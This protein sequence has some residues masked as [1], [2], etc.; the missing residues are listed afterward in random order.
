MFAFR[1]AANYY[2]PLFQLVQAEW[3]DGRIPLWNPYENLGVPLAANSTASVFYPGKLFFAVPF[4]YD[5]AYK[6]YVFSHVL[7]AAFTSYRLARHWG[8]GV[9]GAGV[10]AM[11]YAFCGNVIMQ[12][13]NV[14]YLIGAAWL[15]AALLA[16]DHMLMNRSK[17]WAVALGIILGLI[18]LGGDPQ[19]AYHVGLLTIFYALWCG[20]NESTRLSDVSM[21]QRWPTLLGISVVVALVLS[22]VQVVPSAE[23][24]RRCNRG[25]VEVP[26]NIYEVP[27]FVGYRDAGKRIADGLLVRSLNPERHR[28]QLYHF[29]VGPW[30]LSEYIFPNVSGRQYPVHRRWL[31][32]VPAEGRVW[33]PSLY[34]GLLPFVLAI[35][36]LRFGRVSGQESWLSWLV[37]LAILASFGW[38]GLTWLIH[39]GQQAV[40][41]PKVNI[42]PPVGGLYWMLTV[43]L[44]GY[45]YFRYP[46]K[47]LIIAALALSMLSARGWEHAFTERSDK[48][49]KFLLI[50]ACVSLV[51]TVA[52][53]FLSRQLCDWLAHVEPDMLF[54]PLD[55]RGAVADMLSATLQTAI[56]SLFA[57]GLLRCASGGSRLASSIAV[58]LV[59][60]D[61][62]VA[63]GWMVV[64]APAE[65]WMRGKSE[66]A[67]AVNEAANRTT[68]GQPYRVGRKPSWVSSEWKETSSMDRLAES[69][70]WERNTLAPKY[71]LID[72]IPLSEV[73]G[74]AMPKDYKAVLEKD[75]TIKGAN[76]TISIEKD[77]VVENQKYLPRIWLGRTKNGE[78]LGADE[79][80]IRYTTPGQ[81]CR[82]T[83]YGSQRVEADVVLESPSIVVLS[84]QFYPGWQLTVE[85]EGQGGSRI[86]PMVR[87]NRAM[88]GVELPDGRHHLIYSFRSVSFL[89]GACISAAG[90]SVLL[91]ALVVLIARHFRN[92]KEC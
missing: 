19:T 67:A 65:L 60:V 91:I 8:A 68:G 84:D 7:L 29:S 61:L 74:A 13:S 27:S 14:V 78:R 38:C 25:A 9:Q 34:M 62:S 58:I 26:R 52:I 56:V 79:E 3:L 42:G 80:L 37:V 21:L 69:I 28:Q 30:R 4:S 46:A 22:A 12:Y 15:P 51:G 44:P 88:R 59:A 50:L 71:N 70:I 86:L 47:L 54:G 11:S 6:I 83:H 66:M 2:Y 1:D 87:V 90:W 41:M 45:V 40:G 32:V 49:R 17:R 24:A 81:S 16:A 5:W 36:G 31:E 53:L 75:G 35:G 89:F 63:N 48:L 76:A 20:N 10:G 72:R 55:A 73:Y 82:I 92:R 39:E 85:T 57:W 43:M 33:V 23:F 77:R 64:G 18:I